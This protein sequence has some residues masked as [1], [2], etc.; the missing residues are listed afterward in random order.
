MRR[1]PFPDISGNRPCCLAIASAMSIALGFADP[2]TR[3]LDA[4]LPNQSVTAKK[5]PSCDQWMSRCRLNSR[6]LQEA[7]RRHQRQAG[8]GAHSV[9]GDADDR[10]EHHQQRR[11]VQLE[12]HA[13]INAASP[14]I[15]RFRIPSAGRHDTA[16]QAAAFQA[17]LPLFL[18]AVVVQLHDHLFVHRQ[19]RLRQRVP[20]EV[21]GFAEGEEFHPHLRRGAGV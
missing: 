12:Q 18:A 14:H 17:R 16:P 4:S 19:L 13:R 10:K 6:I 11:I 21:Y 2:N 8:P 20:L 9:D 7:R 5:S 1:W 15:V 3:T